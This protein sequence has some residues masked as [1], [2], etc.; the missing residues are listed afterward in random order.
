MN[1]GS[2]LIEGE[3]GNWCATPQLHPPKHIANPPFPRIQYH[4]RAA[5]TPQPQPLLGRVPLVGRF[6]VLGHCALGG[7]VDDCSLVRGIC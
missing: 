6:V 3:T 7:A 1:L 5:P 4:P 2:V